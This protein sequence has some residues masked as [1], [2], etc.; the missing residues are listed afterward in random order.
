[1]IGLCRA[2]GS[3]VGRFICSGIVG[4]VLIAELF[5]RKHNIR[6]GWLTLGNQRASISELDSSI[7]CARVLTAVGGSQIAEKDLY[8]RMAAKYPDERLSFVQ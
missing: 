3:L 4:R 8:E 2:G 1:M 7:V 6:P 5:G